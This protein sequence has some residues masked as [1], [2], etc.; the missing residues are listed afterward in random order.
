L[1]L[2]GDFTPPSRF[3]RASFLNAVAL[4]GKDGI[5][6]VKR[7]FKVLNQF[8][9]P[10]GAVKQVR[11]G[12]PEYEETQWT[13]AA[14]LSGKRYYFHTAESRVIR[15]IDLSALNPKA[16]KYISIPMNAPETILDLTKRL[17]WQP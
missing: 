9:I 11:D 3:I 7:T 10:V 15:T 6:Q 13:S 16:D 14:D 1:G 17:Q 12:K 8:D 5:G 2:P 4:P